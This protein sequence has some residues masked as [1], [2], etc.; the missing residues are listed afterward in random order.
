MQQSV[1]LS[2]NCLNNLIILIFLFFFFSFFFFL[3]FEKSSPKEHDSEALQSD[4]LQ[5]AM[6][7]QMLRGQRKHPTSPRFQS[8]S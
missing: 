6:K 3:E 8:F 7:P 4:F 1:S 5:V 2:E